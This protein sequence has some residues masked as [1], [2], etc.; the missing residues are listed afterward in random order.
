MDAFG[1]S[2]EALDK[3]TETLTEPMIGLYKTL[4]SGWVPPLTLS[5]LTLGRSM[6]I[7]KKD[8]ASLRAIGIGSN[9]FLPLEKFLSKKVL[10]LLKKLCQPEQFGGGL[11]CGAD[12]IAFCV[13]V[14]LS[15]YPDRMV[16]HV[17]MKNAFGMIERAI[18]LKRLREA[19]SPTLPYVSSIFRSAGLSVIVGKDGKVEVMRNL[20]GVVQGSPLSPGLF[21][22]V[23]DRALKAARQ[24]HQHV[25]ILAIADDAFLLGTQEDVV[26]CMATLAEEC[27]KDNL[28]LQ[29]AKT[30]FY[31]P[32]EQVRTALQ[33]DIDEDRLEGK[34]CPEG[35]VVAGIPVARTRQFTE[36]FVDARVK[37]T[38]ELVMRCMYMPPS[39]GMLMYR[40]CVQ[41][42]WAHLW[43][44]GCLLGLEQGGKLQKLEQLE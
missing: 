21:C 16:A 25:V 26:A 6:G 38:A 20:Q 23:F 17:D 27:M 33:A 2:S 9:L 32:S 24:K 28:T 18:I 41:T 15:L 12:A 13:R 8:K 19:D 39:V 31:S 7:E 35:I 3:F 14:Y 43:R 44:S 5:F 36:Q 34:V 11:P 30:E 22:L 40:Q 10:V 4:G 29:P 42:K 37:E 1:F